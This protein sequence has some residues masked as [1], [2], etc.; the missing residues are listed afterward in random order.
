MIHED[1]PAIQDMLKEQASVNSEE[2]LTLKKTIKDVITAMPFI[3]PWTAE[4]L[5]YKLAIKLYKD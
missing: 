2:F 1:N 4:R 5:A 3:T